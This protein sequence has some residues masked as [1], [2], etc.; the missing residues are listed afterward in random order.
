MIL[1]NI[2]YCRLGIVG[3]FNFS[4]ISAN[5]FCTKLTIKPNINILVNPCLIHVHK[6]EAL[7][8]K[9]FKIVSIQII[10]GQH[11]HVYSDT[12]LMTIKQH[13]QVFVW[14]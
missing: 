2:V 12:G 3:N 6:T 8:P 13:Y 5:E 11:K 7:F 9:T 10:I 4:A 1:I 14:N